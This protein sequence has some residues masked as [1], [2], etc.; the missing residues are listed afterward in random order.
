LRREPRLVP[1]PVIVITSDDQPETRAR[2]MKG[3]ASAMIINLPLWKFRGKSEK[4]WHP[5]IRS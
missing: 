4:D 3:G 5:K 2:V 1:I